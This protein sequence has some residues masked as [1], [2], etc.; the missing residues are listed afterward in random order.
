MG[1]GKVQAR[2]QVTIPK[3]IREAAGVQPGDTLLFTAEAKG[4]FH[5]I[6][7]PKRSSLN[8]ILGQCG[9]AA[10]T[11][12][13]DKLWEQVVESIARDVTQGYENDNESGRKAAEASKGKGRNE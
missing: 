7:I 8:E 11:V 1:F 4:E 3:E 10:G 9:G 2:G 5:V 6:V 12:E 13:S